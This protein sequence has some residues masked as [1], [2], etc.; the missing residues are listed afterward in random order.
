MGSEIT[1]LTEG[2]SD[3]LANFQEICFLSVPYDTRNVPYKQE[4]RLWPAIESW[5][6][7]SAMRKNKIKQTN[8]KT[9]K[10]KPNIFLFISSLGYGILL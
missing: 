9:N 10:K 6:S 2:T 7:R 5:S 3:I 8:K 4:S 1:A